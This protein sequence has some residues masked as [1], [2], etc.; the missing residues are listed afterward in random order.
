MAFKHEKKKRDK[1]PHCSFILSRCLC[2][3]KVDILSPIPIFIAQFPKENKHALNTVNILNFCLKPLTVVITE[4]FDRDPDSHLKLIDFLSALKAP[5]LIFKSPHSR[6]LMQEL[7]NK[8][9]KI[10]GLIFIDGTWDKAK[11][12]YFQSK[13]LQDIPTFHFDEELISEY[14]IRKTPM[15]NALS[16]LESVSYSLEK[17]CHFLEAR[18][19]KGPFQQMI[20]D[21]IEKMGPAYKNKKE[22]KL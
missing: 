21:Q 3:S 1:C 19:L 9:E 5:A 14:Q 4:G 18:K 13:I 7:V 8:N 10:D 2:L 20:N 15:K 11:K 17:C 22:I 16:T 12:I 6:G